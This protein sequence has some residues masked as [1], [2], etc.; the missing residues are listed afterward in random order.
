[1]L[2]VALMCTFLESR[3][4]FL[5]SLWR[6]SNFRIHWLQPPT[7]R[8]RAITL[9][10]R[11]NGRIVTRCPFVRACFPHLISG[12]MDLLLKPKVA[13]IASLHLASGDK[14]SGGRH[15]QRHHYFVLQWACRQTTA[16][17]DAWL[18]LHD[19]YMQYRVPFMIR[20]KTEPLSLQNMRLNIT[21][22]GFENMFLSSRLL[23]LNGLGFAHK[24]Y[25]QVL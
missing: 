10:R 18:Q 11:R 19:T 13:T 25:P 17:K 4:P 20:A 5:D 23:H 16:S 22:T 24:S 3:S 7:R 14:L 1:M 12:R 2:W 6:S 8:L 15:K 21:R 9:A